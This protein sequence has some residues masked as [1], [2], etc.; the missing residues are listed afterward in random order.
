MKQTD[1]NIENETTLARQVAHDIRSPLSALNILKHALANQMSDEAIEIMSGAIDRLN[2]IANDLLNAQAVQE[3]TQDRNLMSE[4]RQVIDEKKIIHGQK[5]KIEFVNHLGKLSELNCMIN[6]ADLQ[7]M[8][9]N[10]LNNAIEAFEGKMGQVQVD[11]NIFPFFFEIAISDNGK[12]IPQHVIEKLGKEGYSFE[13]K[14][15]GLGLYHARKVLA[16]VGGKLVITSRKGFG[17]KVVLRVP[18]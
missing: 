4:I 8:T 12:G 16:E 5:I 2:A 15:S 13:K 11:V 18:R 10:I 1:Q 9:S 6:K 14:G 17:T 3:S 7:R